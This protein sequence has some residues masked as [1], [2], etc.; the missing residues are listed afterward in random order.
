[1]EP[2]DQTTCKEPDAHAIDAERLQAQRRVHD[3]E[4]DEAHTECQA[5]PA[6]P[7]A[8]WIEDTLEEA[9][10]GVAEKPNGGDEE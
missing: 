7:E 8:V 6:V 4:R 1:V 5:A 3:P 2:S 9:P 10:G